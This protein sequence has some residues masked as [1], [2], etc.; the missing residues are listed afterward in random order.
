MN[1]EVD[2]AQ[3]S[4]NKRTYLYGK[5]QKEPAPIQSI[6]NSAKAN[7]INNEQEIKTN[8]SKKY[9]YSFSVEKN[10]EEKI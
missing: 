8:Y 4:N 3:L 2:K 5:S 10:K 1:V 9:V 7:K 6:Q